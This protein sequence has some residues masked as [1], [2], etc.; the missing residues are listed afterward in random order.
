MGT[1]GGVQYIGGILWVHR[2][3][4]STSE[5]SH[6][7]IGGIPWVHRGD[8]M[9]TSGNVQYIGGISWYMWGDTMSTSGDVQ[10]IGGIPW[11]HRGISW[12]HRG[13]IMSTLGDVQYIG[14]FNRNWKD[15]IKLLPHMYHDI[16]PMYWT[17]PDVL[18]ISPWCTHDIP[19]MY[20]TSPDVLMV[21]PTFIMISLRRT[22][23]PLMYSWYPPD[24]PM[25]SPRCTEHPPMY[26]TP[27]D[28]LNIPRRTEHTLYRVILI[29]NDPTSASKKING[30]VPEL[31]RFRLLRSKQRRKNSLVFGRLIYSSSGYF[32][33]HIP[34]SLLLSCDDMKNKSIQC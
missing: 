31:Q 19:P 3:M 32:R 22:E 9:S 18:M 20:W 15:F 11:V 33:H 28:V 12:V 29:S 8:I 13:D 26:W 30:M 21:S 5:G 23:H 2:G 1:S 24:V 27:P 34:N 25:I 17:S 4:F 16:P 7:Y 14:V 6:E 10:Y